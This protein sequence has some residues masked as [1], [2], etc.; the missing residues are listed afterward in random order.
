MES[1]KVF[2]DGENVLKSFR[3]RDKKIDYRKFLQWLRQKWK[4]ASANFYISLNLNDEEQQD[5]LRRMISLGYNIKTKEIG[6]LL[7]GRK[8]NMDPEITSDMM[9][10][11]QSKEAN[12]V[13]LVSGDA[14][15]HAP[16]K[17]LKEHGFKTVVIG[18]SDNTSNVI[19]NLV[20]RDNFIRL[21][22]IIKDIEREEER[23]WK[24]E[25]RQELKNTSKRS[26]D[27]NPSRVL[28]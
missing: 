14:D 5:F 12:T 4:I 6:T 8:K 16:L 7:M 24:D 11:L 2:I 25:I 10:L 3:V 1:A 23:I 13:I 28:N 20:G 27:P 21:E 18:F 15:F 26:S 19:V 22:T 9:E 17:K